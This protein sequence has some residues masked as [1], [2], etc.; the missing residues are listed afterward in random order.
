MKP[1]MAKPVDQLQCE[2]DTAILIMRELRD[3]IWNKS[4]PVEFLVEGQVSV[5]R[6]ISISQQFNAANS[7]LIKMDIENNNGKSKS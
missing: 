3:A 1:I 4:E 5:V 2:R 6:T 7:F